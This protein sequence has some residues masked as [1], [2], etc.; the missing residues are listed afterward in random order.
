MSFFEG[1]F[2]EVS[3]TCSQTA[4]Q[5]AQW[6]YIYVQAL[7]SLRFAGH[8]CDKYPFLMCWHNFI[9]HSHQWTKRKQQISQREAIQLI[10][11]LYKTGYFP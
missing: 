9:I 11:F 2:L 8:L 6:D 5:T 10:A 4:Q 3:A 1:S 7:L